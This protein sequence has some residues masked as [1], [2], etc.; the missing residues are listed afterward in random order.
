MSKV[1][2]ACVAIKQGRINDLALLNKSTRRPTPQSEDHFKY[3]IFLPRKPCFST[4]ME[5]K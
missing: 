1:W 4:K 3:T 5:A 2:E